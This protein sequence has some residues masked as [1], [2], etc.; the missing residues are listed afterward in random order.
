MLSICLLFIFVL[1]IPYDI[2]Q[3]INILSKYDKNNKVDKLI[4]INF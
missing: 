3:Y 2:F 1:L 4:K